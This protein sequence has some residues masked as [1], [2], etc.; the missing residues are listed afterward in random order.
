MSLA[1]QAQ[2][3]K[4]SE[5]IKDANHIAAFTGAGISVES[6][7]PPF[8][9][10]GGIWNKYPPEL[11]EISHFLTDP[12][13]TW[14]AIKDIFYTFEHTVKPNEA[15][16]A[17]AK[18]EAR[19]FLKA[20]I[21]QNIDNLHQEAGSKTIF[22]F[23]GNMK[24]VICLDCQ[25]EFEVM[26]ILQD[27]SM[28]PPLCPTCET[29]L[30]KPDFIFFGEDIPKMAYRNAMDQAKIADLFIVVG[31][32]GQVVP[33]SYIPIIAKQNGCKIIEINPQ[34]SSYTNTITDLF[35]QCKAGEAL[36]QIVALIL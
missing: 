5:M 3:S 10:E 14:K 31:T 1:L 33:A 9:G 23:H 21:T 20:I 30:L 26:H 36:K 28:I 7:I 16:I 25:A 8:R 29:G 6:G 13:T 27:N 11:L 32:T 2:I 17:L 18:L 22:E 19:G 4:A 24:Y 15:H 12:L 35:I 34:P